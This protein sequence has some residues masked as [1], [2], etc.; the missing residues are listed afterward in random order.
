MYEKKIPKD[1]SCGISITFEII[2]GKWKPCLIDSIN[3][4]IRRPSELVKKHPLASKRV[5]NLQLKELETYGVVRKVIYP[6]LPPKV[7]YFLTEV[8]ESLLPL[9]DMMENWGSDFMNDFH[10]RQENIHSETILIGT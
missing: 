2:G 10:E 4:G 5:L 3:Q 8:G 1:F 9:V 6:V 7:E